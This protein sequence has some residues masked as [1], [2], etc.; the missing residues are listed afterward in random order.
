M[1]TTTKRSEERS[2]IHLHTV[3]S[4]FIRSYREKIE[5][6]LKSGKRDFYIEGEIKRHYDRALLTATA[7]NYKG[8]LEYI[9][10]IGVNPDAIAFYLFASLELRGLH[11]D[12]QNN[13]SLDQTSFLELQRRVSEIEFLLSDDIYYKQIMGVAA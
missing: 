9:E 4:K 7:L 11:E 10:L 13:K 8:C 1:E 5:P 3:I 6:F 12:L 2:K